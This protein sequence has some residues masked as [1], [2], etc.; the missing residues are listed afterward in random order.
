MLFRGTVEESSIEYNLFLYFSFK[1]H[2][3]NHHPKEILSL[4]EFF[5]L[6][7]E[8]VKETDGPLIPEGDDA[9]P[10]GD[11]P[12]PG[13]EPSTDKVLIGFHYSF[14]SVVLPYLIEIVLVFDHAIHCI[15]RNGFYLAFDTYLVNQLLQILCV[16]VT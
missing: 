3:L 15:L 5:K 10:P 2:V 16:G 4:D 11:E 8:V 13:M 14:S 6:R 9:P 12:P 7:T 1:K